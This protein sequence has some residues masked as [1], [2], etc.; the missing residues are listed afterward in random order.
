VSTSAP[1]RPVNVL[2][3]R[4]DVRYGHEGSIY[5][6]PE[7]PLGDYPRSLTDRLDEWAARE[8]SRTF[9]A[10]REPEG[11]WRTLNYAEFRRAARAVAQALIDRGLSAEHPVV[12]LSGNDMEHALVEVGAMYAGIPYAPISPAWSLSSS[13]FARLREVIQRLSPGLVF[14]ADGAKFQKAIQAAVPANTQVVVTANPPPARATESF[15][16]FSASPATQAV[17]RAHA[18]VTGDTIA[19]I[20]FTSG[21][22]GT[23]KGV[24]NTQRMLCSNQE[25]LR[26]VYRVLVDEPPVICDWLPWNHTFGGNHNFGLVLY[27]GG[28]LYIDGGRPIPGGFD[29]TLRNLGDVSPNVYFN[30]PKGYEM[31]VESLRKSAPLRDKFFRRL[32]MNFYAAASLPQRVW[33]DLDDISIAHCGERVR[34]LTGLGMTETSPFA[35]SAGSGTARAGFIGLPV[36][37]VEVKLAPVEGKMEIRHRGPNVTPGFWRQDDLTRAAFDD[38]GFFRS[39][40]AAR[41][42]DSA[43]PGEGLIFDGRLTED[44]KLST[45]T[46]VSVGPL[47]ARFIAHC[48]PYVRDAVIAGH[49]RDEI[50]ALVFLDMEQC[51]RIAGDCSDAAARDRVRA[52]LESLLAT[53]AE[54]A[55]GSSNRIARA[56]ILEEPASFDAGEI[57]DKGTINQRAVLSRRAHLVKDLYTDPAPP[58][59]IVVRSA[60]AA[61]GK[62]E[63]MPQGSDR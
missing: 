39:G 47:R 51:G 55:T 18:R 1:F 22:A 60:V 56:V 35:I 20:L 50:A 4:V 40:D 54:G 12:V 23:P 28:S 10:Q 19:K 44:F 42:F 14:A 36:P 2:S 11:G 26:T 53:L 62:S 25:M 41:F 5:L 43:A 32:K 58:H 7:T 34:M 16:A 24:I 37:G 9:L 45:G 49:D 33:D 15:S 21:S 57:T 63:S 3:W 59:V 61:G 17:E 38:E 13:D 31:L 6:R 52:E 29:E 8:P 30:V 48:A 27:N 46:W